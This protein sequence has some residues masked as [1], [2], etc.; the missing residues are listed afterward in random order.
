MREEVAA[1]EKVSQPEVGPESEQILT[2]STGLRVVELDDEDV[3]AAGVAMRNATSVSTT[4][5]RTTKVEKTHASP[6]K[7][8]KPYPVT[9]FWKS[10]SL[11]GGRTS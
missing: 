8:S 10:T 5:S 9:S 2:S 11:I 6:S 1:G 3:V 7:P 4:C